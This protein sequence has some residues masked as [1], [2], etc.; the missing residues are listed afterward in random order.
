MEYRIENLTFLELFPTWPVVLRAHLVFAL[1][2]G[3]D[4]S[5]LRSYVG[6]REI[7]HVQSDCDNMVEAVGRYIGFTACNSRF[8]DLPASAIIATSTKTSQRA[9]WWMSGRMRSSKT[10]RNKQP[11]RAFI[12]FR[13]LAIHVSTYYSPRVVFHFRTNM[14]ALSRG[15]GVNLARELI[16]VDLP[17]RRLT[18][19]RNVVVANRDMINWNNL[20]I[21]WRDHRKLLFTHVGECSCKR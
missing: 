7:R 2:M 1:I 13:A 11:L 9:S 3:L 10:H 12:S 4:S 16:K 8:V 17:T 21:S 20:P 5:Q 19:T 6:I 14:P 15:A 18:G